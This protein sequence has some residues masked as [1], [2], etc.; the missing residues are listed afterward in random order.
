MK[1]RSLLLVLPLLLVGGLAGAQESKAAPEGE[2]AVA[3]P[4]LE[5]LDQKMS[6]VLGVQIGRQLSPMEFEINREAFTRGVQ[7]SL[8]G[9]ELLLSQEEIQ[10]AMGEYMQQAQKAQTE[11]AASNMAESQAFLAQNQERP[12]VKTTESGL[13]YE[14]IEEGSGESPEATSQVKVHYR[15][16][17]VDGEEFDSSYGGDPAEFGLNQVI[18]GWKEGLQLMKEG[19]KYKLYLPPDLAYGERAPAAIGPNQAL[20]FEVEL[21]DVMEADTPEQSNAAPGAAE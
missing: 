7:D 20:I 9:G 19:A 17:L 1:K 3:G 4:E 21:L 11:A 12:E 10:A 6:Y 5:T 8:E 15:G 14:V 18:T 16:T 2:T 13:Q